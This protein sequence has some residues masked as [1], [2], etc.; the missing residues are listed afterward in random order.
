M[1]AVA[2]D[3]GGFELKTKVLAHLREK[4]YECRDFGT[5]SLAS[6]DYTDFG[7]PAAEAVAS[8][9]CEKG[10]VIC[11]TGIGISITANKV[12]GVRCALCHN[13]TT[14]RMT[15]EHNNSNVLAIGAGMVGE[16]LALEMVDTFL[17][18]PFSGEERHQRRID[19]M[20]A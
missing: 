7:R 2:S 10:I 6:C 17:K 1:I 8:G 13:T 20:E 11:T 16:V 9:E 12:R 14:A 19:K 4:G 15:R 18:T 3:H 5:N